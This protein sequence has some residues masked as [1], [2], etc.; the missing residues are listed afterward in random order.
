MLLR[1]FIQQTA[2]ST[3]E[4]IKDLLTDKLT[5]IDKAQSSET[6]TETV[7]NNESNRIFDKLVTITEKLDLIQLDNDRLKEENNRLKSAINENLINFNEK[8]QSSSPSKSDD[9]KMKEFEE[10]LIHH[11]G[12]LSTQ[13]ST[14]K[15]GCNAKIFTR[16]SFGGNAHSLEWSFSALNKSLSNTHNDIRPDLFQ[17]WHSFEST[18]WTSFDSI[19]NTIKQHSEQLSSILRLLGSD[20]R[21]AQPN[22]RTTPAARSALVSA[23]EQDASHGANMLEIQNEIS[24][25][26]I[27][28]G[29]L[30]EKIS[31]AIQVIADSREIKTMESA[32]LNIISN[33]EDQASTDHSSDLDSQ[34]FAPNHNALL[35][36]TNNLSNVNSHDISLENLRTSHEQLI[37]TNRFANNTENINHS[38]IS[39][40]IDLQCSNNGNGSSDTINLSIDETADLGHDHI[41]GNNCDTMESQSDAKNEICVSNLKVNTTET[42]VLNYLKFKGINENRIIKIWRL[43]KKESDLSSF[44]YISFK[45]DTTKDTAIELKSIWPSGCVVNDF[46]HKTKGKPLNK[47]RKGSNCVSL[48][49]FFRTP[50][51]PAIRT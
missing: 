22:D 13:I 11:I 4:E 46:I 38:S 2:P 8:I 14:Q 33:N 17:L 19:T 16:D 47:V 32:V 5:K 7:V 28:V 1:Q 30:S 23:I 24:E 15:T 26:K 27:N 37:S 31:E 3:V 40:T 39:T 25:L 20:D 9:T 36:V 51:Q 48:N 6:A 18:T 10:L 34:L 35:A 43:V 21:I 45:I 29:R 50:S 41:D 44:D 12:Q 42:D 49:D